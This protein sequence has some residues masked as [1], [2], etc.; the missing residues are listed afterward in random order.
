[1][2]SLAHYFAATIAVS[3]PFHVQAV[4]T[5]ATLSS[6]THLALAR[7]TRRLSS[8]PIMSYNGRTDSLMGSNGSSDSYS[9][10]SYAQSGSADQSG[11]LGKIRANRL[12]ILYGVIALL[13][14]II[15]ALAAALHSAQSKE[16][17]GGNGNNNNNNPATSSTG[18]SAP[19]TPTLANL[20][21]IDKLMTHASALQRIADA[22]G[23]NRYI[24]HAGFNA[25]VAYIESV[26]RANASSFAISKQYFVR[27][28]F[29][30]VGAPDLVVTVGDDSFTY[31]Y[32][33]MYNVYVNSWPLVASGVPLVSVLNGGCSAAEWA[34]SLPANKTGAI[35]VV[36]RSTCSSAARETLAR[37]NGAIGVIQYNNDPTTGLVAYVSALTTRITTLSMRYEEGHALE[38]IIRAAAQQQQNA[39]T[40]PTLALNLTTLTP[41]V[42]ITNL[43]ADT[44]TGDPT[45]TIVIGSHS[46]GVVSGAGIVDNGSGTCGNLVWAVGV[47][48]L[49]QT[50]G[51]EAFPNRLR[52]CWWGGEE[53]GLLGSRYHV[54]VAKNATEVGNR[55]ADYQVNLNHVSQLS[56]GTHARML[57]HPACVLS[58]V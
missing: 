40:L 58:R 2:L 22:N 20:V 21:T 49:L 7:S 28:G 29:E 36:V 34:A 46:D 6:L 27:R 13:S 30:V 43:C 1:M 32:G 24:N 35:A 54:D 47:H 25:S 56:T 41:D 33:T 26:L 8:L 45:S 14:I 18:S 15:I 50:A 17:D 38:L 5:V 51:Y 42:T 52:F 39:T 55:L 53:E 44:P 9:S 12:Y 11:L 48:D 16:G 57:A 10:A 31:A 3:I 23:G 37:A 4:V 19:T